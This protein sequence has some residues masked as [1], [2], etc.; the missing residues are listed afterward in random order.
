MVREEPAGEAAITYTAPEDS[1]AKRAVI[2]T[3]ERLTGQARLERIYHR[4]RT[5][6]RPGDNIWA[7]AIEELRLKVRCDISRLGEV[8]GSGRP[9]VVV[10]NH[11]F[12]VVDGLVLCHLVATVR[13]DLKVVAM[14][15]LARVPELRDQV[16]P[17][18]F[19]NTRE[20]IETSARSRVAARTH[21]AKGGCLI[22][23]PAGQVSTSPGPFVRLAEDAPWHPFAGR[24]VLGSKADVLPVRFFGQNSR[25]FQVASH[26]GK[27]SPTLRLSLLM[28]EAVRRIGSTVE[29]RSA[30]SCRSRRC[31]RWASPSRW[32]SICA[33]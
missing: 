31:G 9:L 19:A 32:S 8:P 4:A 7:L 27:I 20:A 1:P 3:I 17:I 24:L 15:T 10:A 18:N 14:S 33:R 22:I 21:L 30:S 11:P 6:L 2:R 23:F 26:L 13:Q 16:L 29:C 25:L 5:R 28:G 12:G